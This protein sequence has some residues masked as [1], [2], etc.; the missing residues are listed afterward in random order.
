MRAIPWFFCPPIFVV[1]IVAHPLG[2]VRFVLM[3]TFINFFTNLKI[4][5]VFFLDCSFCLHPLPPL[6]NESE[7]TLLA[8]SCCRLLGLFAAAETNTLC[9]IQ[10]IDL[11]V[12]V[13]G[14]S[15][16]FIK[17]LRCF[18]GFHLANF[19][20]LLRVFAGS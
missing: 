15:T 9:L 16:K 1:A 2:I 6:A 18:G 11:S 19:L 17:F 14:L 20:M 3:A 12:I 10:G 13:L 7:I 4:F 5:Y 8:V